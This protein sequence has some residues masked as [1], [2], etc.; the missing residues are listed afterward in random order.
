MNNSAIFPHR[1]E[2]ALRDSS[3]VAATTP[4]SGVVLT[5]ATRTT[6]SATDPAIILRNMTLSARTVVPDFLRLVCT[7]AGTGTTNFH[8]AATIS[9]NDV[10]S[11]FGVQIGVVGTKNASARASISTVYVRDTSLTTNAPTNP[12]TIARKVLKTSA[13]AVGDEF[14]LRFGGESGDGVPAAL[15]AGGTLLIYVW[16]SGMTAAPS[17]EVLLGWYE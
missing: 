12:R 4:G 10:Y 1:Q 7:A 3:Y 15:H 16:G 5:S 13:L 9:A 11:E 14:T 2:L 8:A 17:F 6:Y